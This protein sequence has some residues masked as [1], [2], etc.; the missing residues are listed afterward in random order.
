M[1]ESPESEGFSAYERHS[2]EYWKDTTHNQYV[3]IKNADFG[4][5]A[6]LRTQDSPR[7][8]MAP[9]CNSAVWLDLSRGYYREVRYRN[10]RLATH[11]ARC[12]F[13]HKNPQTLHCSGESSQLDTKADF[14]GSEQ[15]VRE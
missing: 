8:L 1:T 11:M 2:V 7:T 5:L 9:S 4:L 3:K 12:F 13:H 15:R 14:D 6:S 10:F